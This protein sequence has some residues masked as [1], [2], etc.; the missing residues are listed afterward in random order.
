[1][2]VQLVYC[3]EA[4]HRGMILLDKPGENKKNKAYEVGISLLA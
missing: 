4:I 3:F 1:V 2:A